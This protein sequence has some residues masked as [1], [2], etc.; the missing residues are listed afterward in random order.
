VSFPF[1]R[2]IFVPRSYTFPV[3]IRAKLAEA[4]VLISFSC[5]VDPRE[6]LLAIE[7][8]NCP[9]L[10]VGAPPALGA[11]HGVSMEA[12]VHLQRA[13]SVP[14]VAPSALMPISVDSVVGA[15]VDDSLWRFLVPGFD[16]LSAALFAVRKSFRGFIADDQLV[17]VF[18][19]VHTRLLQPLD[20]ADLG[21]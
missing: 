9:A 16:A 13:T 10:V 21:F 5:T 14:A 6:V 18:G 7:V 1:L 8:K 11:I 19:R 2:I 3:G 17:F 4:K 15:M 12:V 20:V